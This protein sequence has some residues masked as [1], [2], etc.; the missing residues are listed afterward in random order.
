MAAYFI[1]NVDVKDP[2]RYADY[3]RAAPS[4]IARYGGRYL[5][6]GGA[7]QK[8]EGTYDPKRVVILEFESLERA[9]EWWASEEYRAPKALRQA[10]AVTDMILVQGV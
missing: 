5:V 2:D 10:T 7:A 3:I 8:V 6:R 1:V 4:S 9:R